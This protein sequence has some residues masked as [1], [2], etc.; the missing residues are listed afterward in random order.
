[1]LGHLP[2]SRLVAGSI[3]EEQD[4]IM[5]GYKAESEE[6][7]LVFENLQLLFF[8]ESLD[9]SEVPIMVLRSFDIG[10]LVVVLHI[11]N[12]VHNVSYTNIR[13]KF[14]GFML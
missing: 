10:G 4:Q 6:E 9:S 1:M 13:E 12:I 14:E 8:A 3:A 2:L 7:L 11:P 5:Y